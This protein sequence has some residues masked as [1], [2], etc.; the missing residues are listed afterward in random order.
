MRPISPAYINSNPAKYRTHK[1]RVVNGQ[2]N[3]VTNYI[4]SSRDMDGL[5]KKSRY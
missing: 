5:W 4:Y 3:N 2:T 1:E